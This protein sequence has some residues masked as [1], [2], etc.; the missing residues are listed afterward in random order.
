VR[1]SRFRFASALR[2]TLSSDQDFHHGGF[3][4]CSPSLS[5]ARTR[6]V[7]LIHC[8]YASRASAN[9]RAAQIQDL[10]TKARASN[11]AQGI[12]GI[13]LL[14]DVSFFQVLEGEAPVVDRIYETIVR[15]TRHDR[16]TQII[17]EPIPQRSF[18]EW[19]MGYAALA[20]E[21]AGRLIGANDFFDGADCL[22]NIQPGRARKLVV[23]F[24]AGRWRT[25]HTGVHRAHARV[26]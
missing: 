14:I 9:M 1:R 20:R 24:G 18:A 12:T 11:A 2:L 23:A 4:P 3:A 6:I 25:E 5:A 8:I 26:T 21:D 22:E 10:L 13:L 15:D 17:R 16:V 19:S 7:T